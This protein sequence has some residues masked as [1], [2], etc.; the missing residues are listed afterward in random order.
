MSSITS[1]VI[2][3]IQEK[4]IKINTIMYFQNNEK[5]VDFPYFKELCTEYYRSDDPG[6][7]GNFVNGKLDFTD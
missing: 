2:V 5:K 3:I 7:L 6:S 1:I 4:S